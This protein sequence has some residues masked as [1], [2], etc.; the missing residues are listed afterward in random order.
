MV[1]WSPNT[2][3]GGSGG[4]SDPVKPF[5]PEQPPQQQLQQQRQ[6]QQ[7]QQ[8]QQHLEQQ[9]Q[10]QPIQVW[11]ARRPRYRQQQPQIVNLEPVAHGTS[12]TPPSEQPR[13]SPFAGFIGGQASTPSVV[14]QEPSSVVDEVVN[15]EPQVA[16]EDL[17]DLELEAGGQESSKIPEDQEK[18]RGQEDLLQEF[19]DTLTFGFEPARLVQSTTEE[20]SSS[21]MES[22]IV[23]LF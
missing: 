17:Q 3:G 11:T 14:G 7:H 6:P 2:L 1:A 22:N 5:Y 18:V 23:D 9:H 16:G 8:Q 12:P 4:G 20:V 10:Q 19:L 13:A 15:D 21:G